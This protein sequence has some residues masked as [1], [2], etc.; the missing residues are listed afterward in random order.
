MLGVQP[1]E[2]VL[3]PSGHLLDLTAQWRGKTIG[4][5]VSAPEEFVSNGEAA[6]A[7]GGDGGND[8]DMNAAAVAALGPSG[9]AVF[10]D[11]S[12]ARLRRDG[13][14]DVDAITSAQA[15]TADAPRAS[16]PAE[17]FEPRGSTALR[18]RQLGVLDA[19][20]PVAIVEFW[21]WKVVLAGNRYSRANGPMDLGEFARVL[22]GYLDDAVGSSGGTDA[23]G[24][25]DGGSTAKRGGVHRQSARQAKKA[26]QGEVG[27]GGAGA[28]EV[29]AREEVREL[30]SWNQF[31]VANKGKG[32]TMGAL[33]EKYRLYKEDLQARL[34][35]GGDD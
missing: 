5:L 23:A 9:L 32:L 30:L 29:A 33:A 17:Q 13:V 7:G 28:S 22:A 26:R 6:A 4:I 35:R 12:A 27:S 2:H 31:R 8:G 21:Q 34:G 14:V 25:E 1:K 19:S 16:P 24:S 10:D 18:R 15:A 11:R 3:A 20:Q